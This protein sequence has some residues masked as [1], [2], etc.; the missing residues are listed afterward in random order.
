MQGTERRA[1]DIPVEVVG[2]QIKYISIRQQ[3]RQT[4]DDG[5]AIF[6]ADTDID[7]HAVP[8]CLVLADQAGTNHCTKSFQPLQPRAC[9]TGLQAARHTVGH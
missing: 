8:L 7:C 1:G 6:F 2:L 3:A 5:L 9:D 4:L